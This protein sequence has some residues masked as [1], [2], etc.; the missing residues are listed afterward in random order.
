MYPSCKSLFTLE[1]IVADFGDNLSP[2]TATVAKT[3][4]SRRIRRLSPVWTGHN[5]NRWREVRQNMW[6]KAKNDK[7]QAD[8]VQAATALLL[9]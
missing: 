9:C 8:V 4:D 6:E 5:I 3:G 1:T 2:K 7:G